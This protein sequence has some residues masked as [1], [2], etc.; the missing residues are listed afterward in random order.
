MS[1]C[2]KK[3]KSSGDAAQKDRHDPILVGD[4]SSPIELDRL[5][6]ELAKLL[7]RMAAREDYLLSKSK[8]KIPADAHV[9]PMR[10]RKSRGKIILS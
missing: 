7:G 8:D 4:A 3:H 9:G 1:G 10:D 6:I 5:V 2:K